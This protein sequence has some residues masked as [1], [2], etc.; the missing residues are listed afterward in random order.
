MLY[1][2]SKYNSVGLKIGSHEIFSDVSRIECVFCCFKK[3]EVCLQCLCT[4]C[5]I[6]SLFFVF[7]TGLLMTTASSQRQLCNFVWGLTGHET[8]SC[9]CESACYTTEYGNFDHGRNALHPLACSDVYAGLTMLDPYIPEG[10][11]DK[12][13]FVSHSKL[14]CGLCPCGTE[15]CVKKFT[16]FKDDAFAK[17]DKSLNPYHCHNQYCYSS[18]CT[19]TVDEK[20][21]NGFYLNPNK[22]IEWQNNEKENKVCGYPNN[23]AAI[24]CGDMALY[25][26]EQKNNCSNI[27]P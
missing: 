20:V 23:N 4:T 17:G 12:T 5:I 8:C 13:D 24:A 19:D 9:K 15:R 27:K 7:C 11:V 16:D 3:M 18:L 6:T 21:S 25:V 2:G 14:M 1:G 22:W 26:E 10:A